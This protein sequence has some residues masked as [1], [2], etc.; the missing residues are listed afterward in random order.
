M[1][2]FPLVFA[3]A[4]LV[5]APALAQGRYMHG[6]RDVVPLDRILPHIRSAH[7]GKFYDAEGPFM[8]PA[9][10]LHY[11][12]KWMTPEGRIVWFDTDARTG[13]VLG[14]NHG[15]G[16]FGPYPGGELRPPRDDRDFPRERFDGPPRWNDR[17]G[18]RDGPARGDWHG[19]G[20]GP[21]G[22]GGHGGH[23]RPGG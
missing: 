16:G 8:D 2:L 13:R 19:G 15:W 1:R 22:G 9:G 11:R 5:V 3:L 7:P 23:G 10:R 20:D 17:P 4:C 14:V 18:W 21:H 6:R 12:I